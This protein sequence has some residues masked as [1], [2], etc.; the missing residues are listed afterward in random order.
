MGCVCTTESGDQ[1]FIS[2]NIQPLLA[3]SRVRPLPNGSALSDYYPSQIREGYCL[4]SAR[5]CQVLCAN[6][7]DAVR[8][9]IQLLCGCLS[10]FWTSH[11]GTVGPKWP[12]KLPKE[13]SSKIHNNLLDSPQVFDLLLRGVL[14]IK[15][16]PR[17]L[18]FLFR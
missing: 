14:A 1:N 2:E 10:D 15:D 13:F 8:C 5:H 17:G 3:R 4:T 18:G 11:I 7:M 16:M 9:S 6:P 12:S